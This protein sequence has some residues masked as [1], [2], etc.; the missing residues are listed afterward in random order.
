MVKTLKIVKWYARL[1]NNVVALANCLFIALYHNYNIEIPVH[2]FFTS[3]KLTLIKTDEK[4]DY[5][6]DPR[7]FYYRDQIA[8]INPACFNENKKQVLKI[9]RSIF[10]VKYESCEAFADDTLVIHIRSGDL[11]LDYE[12]ER[13]VHPK[14][15]LPPLSYYKHIID[16]KQF[17]KIILV[18]EDNRNPCTSKLLE[19]YPNI[20]FK[21]GSLEDD[22]KLIF[23]AKNLVASY[24]TFISSLTY[25]SKN[26]KNVYYPS[27]FWEFEWL[28][29]LQNDNIKESYINL[30]DYFK[31]IGNWRCN[32]EQIKLMLS[33]KLIN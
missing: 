33:H 15:I 5:I 2:G 7:G 24:G 28:K 1:G 18:S 13:P 32:N 11:I 8:N 9:I 20:I 4:P 17:K 21:L 31:Q 23:S 19:L 10:K 26:I 25:L 14:Y 22:I 3:T 12:N 27:Y 30:D 16:T 6:I 29:F